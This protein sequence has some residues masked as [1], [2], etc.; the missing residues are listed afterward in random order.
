ME[1]VTL[2]AIIL[3]AFM[4]FQKYIGR[5]FAGRWKSVGEALGGGHIYDP[6]ATTE[7][8]YDFQ[9]TN[10]WYDQACFESNGCDCLSVQAN[11]TTCQSCI[12]NCAIARCN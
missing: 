6:R 12:G 2:V 3:I 11:A 4:V 9:Y 5:G 10:S 7:C 8:I 1:Y